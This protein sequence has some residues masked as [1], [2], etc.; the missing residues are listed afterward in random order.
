MTIVFIPNSDHIFKVDF[1]AGESNNAF[2]GVAAAHIGRQCRPNSPTV[3]PYFSDFIFRNI[4]GCCMGCKVHFGVSSGI[5]YEKNQEIKPNSI[6]VACWC[7]QIQEVLWIQKT[8]KE[9]VCI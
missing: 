6:G 9:S 3:K 2:I 1:Q 5:A 4:V 8:N 7:I